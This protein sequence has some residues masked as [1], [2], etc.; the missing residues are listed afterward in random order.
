M[1]HDQNLV[2]PWVREARFVTQYGLPP[3]DASVLADPRELAEYFEACAADADAKVASNWIMTEVLRT[4]KARDWSLADWT[5]RVPAERMRR[6][7]EIDRFQW[8]CPQCDH[9]LHEEHFTV[10]DYR[11]DPVSRAYAN[12]FDSEAHRTCGACGHVMPRPAGA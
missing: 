6:P 8:F 12:F 9:L 11:K 10:D 2:L 3:Y 5:T 7:G 1:S 4:L